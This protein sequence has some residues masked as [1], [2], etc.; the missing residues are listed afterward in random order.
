MLDFRSDRLDYGQLLIPPQGYRLERAIAATYSLDLNTLLSIPIALFYSQT[1]EGKIDGERFQVLEAIR[2]TAETVTVYCQEG[3]IHVPDRYNRL[4]AFMEEMIISVRMADAFSSFHPKVWALRYSPVADGGPV[5]YRVL[6]L[7]RNLTYDRSWD[8]AVTLEGRVGTSARGVNR[9]LVDFLAHLNRIH[10]IADFARFAKDLARVKFE[11][12]AQF[13]RLAFHP[14]GIDGYRASPIDGQDAE[15]ALCISPFIDERTVKGLRDCTQ[16]DFWLFSRQ[17]ELAK[18]P[19]DLVKRCKAYRLS[20][21]VVEGERMEAGDSSNEECAEQDL[22]AKLF[23]FQAPDRC[24]WFLGSANATEAARSRNTE[25]L[26]ELVG[27]DRHCSLEQATDDLMAIDGAFQEFLPDSAGKPDTDAQQRAAIRRL[28]YEM[29]KAPLQG[30]VVRSENAANYDL[31]LHLDLRGI[32]NPA[33]LRVDVRPL[34]FSQSEVVQ[35]GKDNRPVFRNIRESE[36]TRFMAFT[37]NAGGEDVR[38]F[39]LRCELAGIPSARLDTIFQSIVSSREQFF[40]YLEFLLADE[41]SKGDFL[42][43]PMKQRIGTGSEED[44]LSWHAHLPIFERMI[45]AAARDPDRLREVDGVIDRLKKQG[46]TDRPLVPPEFL[47]FWEV[48][49]PL[50]PFSTGRADANER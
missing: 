11:C 16:S 41:L 35:V 50:I 23:V 24:R 33:G 15:A 37:I 38:Q 43:P 47:D 49:R 32:R 18:L 8:L 31:S 44:V 13:D 17:A 20:D 36:I 19:P 39:V 21:W 42:E 46:A 10:P 45:V 28:E 14:V 27:G 22:H 25:F 6:V 2:R 1:L 48:F 40:E 4:F 34:N 30:S 9:P 5:V 26:V 29:I 12:P 3:H 7:S